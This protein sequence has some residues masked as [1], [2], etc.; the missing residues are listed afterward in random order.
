VILNDQTHT[1]RNDQIAATIKRHG[2]E[3]CSLKTAAGAE[4][5]W[6]AGP[7]W[8]RHS[9]LLFPIVGRLKNDALH[10][11]G[12]TYPMGQHGLARDHDFDWIARNDKSCALV[13]TDNDETR[14]RYPFAFRLSVAFAL[15]G[16]DLDISFEVT[17]SGSEVLPASI[18]A[19]P[20]FS[21]PLLPTLA[22]EE[23]ALTFS[24]DEPAPVRRLR[25]GLMRATPESN[26][27]QG[28]TLALS[29]RLFED[30]AIIFDQ[31]K[32]TEVSYAAKTGPSIRVSWN[33]FP[34]LGVWSK[35][36]TTLLCIEPWCGFASPEEFDGE[37]SDKPGLMHLAPGAQRTFNYR[38]SVGG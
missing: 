14:K 20:A 36:G 24:D 19:H 37:F 30:D 27:V 22:K 7:E 10:H 28:R 13:L 12:V 33:G 5:I 2:A 15:E 1:I 8:P 16:S 26:P 3:L 11:R 17:N 9:P 35:L 32:S 31:L 18:G 4:L 21:W 25:G 6:G 23:Y 29:E 34:Q 38:I